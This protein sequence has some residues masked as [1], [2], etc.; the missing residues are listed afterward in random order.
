MMR[1][2]LLLLLAGVAFGLAG[3][4]NMDPGKPGQAGADGLDGTDGAAG[5]NGGDGV[6]G[7]DGVDGEDGNDGND[8]ADGQDGEDGIG[9]DGRIGHDGYGPWGLHLAITDVGGGSGAE[10]QLQI[11]DFPTVTFEVTDDAGR[12]YSLP[13]LETMYVDLSGPTSHYQIAVDYADLDT[14]LD[15]LDDNWDNSWTYTFS[16]P[17]PATF[18]APANDTTD[19][20]YDDGDWGGEALVDGTYTV[21]A[22]V[23]IPQESMDGSTWYEAANATFDVLLGGATVVEPRDVVLAENCASCHGEEFSAHGG[24]RRELGVCLTCHVAGAEDRYSATDSTVTPSTTISFMTLVH[25]LHQGAALADGLVVAGYPAD[26][27]VE[28]YPDYNLVDFSDVTFPRWPMEAATCDACHGGASGG[29]VTEKPSRAACGSCHDDVDYATGDGHDGGMQEDDS[30]C[31]LCHDATTIAGYHDDPRDDVTFNSGLTVDVVGVNGGSGS[32]G[33]LQVGDTITVTYTLTHD[34]GSAAT[35]AE[36]GSA[37]AVFSGP[38]SHFQWILESASGGVVADSVWDAT[39]GTY[40]YTFADP[41]PAAFPAQK[42]DTV[43]I[44]YTQG[45]WYGE[46]LVDGTY[47]VGLMAYLSLADSEGTTWRANDSDTEDVLLGAATSL[48]GRDVV[49]ED[50]CLACHGRLEFHG[51]GREGLD[52]CLMCHTGGGEDRYSSTDATTTPGVTIDFKVLIHKIHA[53]DLLTETYDVNGYGSPYT[54]TNFNDVTFPR[55]DGGVMACVACHEGS[56]AWKEPSTAP[57][58]SCHDTQD[59]ATHAAIMTDE[60]FG[61]TCQTCHGTTQDFAVEAMHDPLR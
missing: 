26:P 35:V 44:G 9:R 23:Y 17:V 38:T 42:N 32:S 55:Q 21:G 52:Y 53:G 37:T 2:P 33:E 14:V 6:D 60:S 4:C 22:W 20:G 13:E 16:Q 10:G 18:H 41:I 39:A 48:E 1:N 12:F 24:T 27:T 30:N 8:G 58:T 36:L 40:A 56:D 57:C 19:L 47:R 51:S 3:G 11:G 34:D 29:N 61:E 28:G 43:D 25:K 31:A 59:A 54:T 7:L 5:A 15:N 45:D 50:N 49:A 46:A